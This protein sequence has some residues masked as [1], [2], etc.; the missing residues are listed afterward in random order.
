VRTLHVGLRVTDMDRSIAFYTSVG[1][2]VLGQVRPAESVSLTMLKLPDDEFVSLEL[3]HNRGHAR[4]DPTGLSHL[5]I[6]VH[7][8]DQTITDLIGRGVKTEAPTSP[9]G[10]NELWT[11]WVTDPAGFRIELVQWPPGHP[12]G[13]TRAD[14]EPPSPADDR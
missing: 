2:E 7:A 14:L 1:Y 4:V 3:V 8:L 5:V 6:N 12:P 9:D 10:S 11:A 13:M